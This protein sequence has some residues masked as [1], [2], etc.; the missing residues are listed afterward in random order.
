M[1]YLF[2]QKTFD[3]RAALLTFYIIH[4]DNG[5]KREDHLATVSGVDGPVYLR[6]AIDGKSTRFSG[7]QTIRPST[8]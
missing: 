5:L 1:N 7:R 3:D 2:L 6:L 4:V 8:P